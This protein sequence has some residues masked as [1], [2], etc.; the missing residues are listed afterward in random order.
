MRIL[1][2]GNWVVLLMRDGHY[3]E[4]ELPDDRSAHKLRSVLELAIADTIEQLQLEDNPNGPLR[5]DS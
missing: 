2:D 1:V 4:L 5:G 3:F